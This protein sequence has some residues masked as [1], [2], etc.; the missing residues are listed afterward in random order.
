MPADSI[1]TLYDIE[2]PIEKMFAH[3]FGESSVA[4]YAPANGSFVD[5]AWRDANPAL[6][7]FILNS[8]EELQR[9]IPRVEFIVRMAAATTHLTTHTTPSRCDCF[10]GTI[11]LTLTTRFNYTEHRLFRGLVRKIMGD[12]FPQTHTPYHDVN[13]CVESGTSPEFKSSDDLMQSTLNYEIHCN[14][15]PGEWPA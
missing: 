10:E 15:K 5:D 11:E 6:A 9:S 2:T 14:I 4:N 12:E 3:L 13:K 8:E 1:A 7:P